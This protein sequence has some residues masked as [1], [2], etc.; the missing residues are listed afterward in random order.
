MRHT[1]LI[2]NTLL[3]SS[4]GLTGLHAQDKLTVTDIDGN[5]YQT[6]TIGTQVWMKENLKVTKYCNGDVIGTTT[7]ASLDISGEDTPKYQ[8]APNGDESNV[9][10]YGR[11]YT[12]HAVTDSRNVCPTGWH[13]PDDAEWATL[14]TFLGGAR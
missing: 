14:T 3:L 10:V 2:L 8:W 1:Q 7:P 4:L 9:A 6:V 13:L 5:V 11:L 12:W